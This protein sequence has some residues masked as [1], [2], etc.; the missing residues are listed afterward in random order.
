[1]IG[2]GLRSDFFVLIIG[3]TVIVQNALCSSLLRELPQL[4]DTCAP[5]VLM[6]SGCLA[7]VQHPLNT[8]LRTG[9]RWGTEACCVLCLDTVVCPG[10]G[11]PYRKVFVTEGNIAGLSVITVGGTGESG[12]SKLNSLTLQKVTTF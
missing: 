9:V 8:H 3:I 1:M 11:R 12:A 7:P 5:F 10:S 4:E 2:D 6:L